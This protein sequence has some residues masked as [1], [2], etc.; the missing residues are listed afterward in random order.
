MEEN[1][2]LQSQLEAGMPQEQ[3]DIE[4]VDEGERHVE[5]VYKLIYICLL[6]GLI[7]WSFGRSVGK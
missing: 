6:T 2:K 7:L 1:K 5:M 3:V 4:H